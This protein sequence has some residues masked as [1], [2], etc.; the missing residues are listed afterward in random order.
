MAQGTTSV[1]LPAGVAAA[2]YLRLYPHLSKFHDDLVILAG[3]AWQGEWPLDFF[4][5]IGDL[6]KS[7]PWLH[8]QLHA[9]LDPAVVMAIREQ[10]HIPDGAMESLGAWKE[11]FPA[12]KVRRGPWQFEG[13]LLLSQLTWGPGVN[14]PAHRKLAA[15][16]AQISHGLTRIR[17]DGRPGQVPRAHP[18]KQ[19]M[20]SSRELLTIEEAGNFLKEFISDTWPSYPRFAQ[21]LR[22]AYL[23]LILGMPRMWDASASEF[24][25]A[26]DLLD[27]DKD[28][29]SPVSSVIGQRPFVDF[30]NLES[31]ELPR[32]TKTFTKVDL[33]E[34][35]LVMV[36]ELTPQKEAMTALAELWRGEKTWDFFESIHRLRYWVHWLTPALHQRFDL[37]AVQCIY[38]TLHTKQRTWAEPRGWRWR[39][40]KYL[41]LEIPDRPTALITPSDK[42]RRMGIFHLRALLLAG[43]IESDPETIAEPDKAL[44][45]VICDLESRFRRELDAEEIAA[46]FKQQHPVEFVL[47]RI[48]NPD[49][50]AGFIAAI[51]LLLPEISSF[52]PNLANLL[53]EAYLPVLK[54]AP[55]IWTPRPEP[56]TGEDTKRSTPRKKSKRHGKTRVRRMR[57]G[58]PG[59]EKPLPGE[60][61]EETQETLELFRR[62]EPRKKAVSLKKELLWVH[63]RV[64]GANP[65]LVRNHF[66]SICDAEAALFVQ[67]LDARI[68]ADLSAKEVTRA[69]TGI[70]VALVLLTGQGPRTWAE[71]KV[72]LSETRRTGNQPRLLLHK[73][74]FELPIV[75]PENSFEP[76]DV[77]ASL[78]EPTASTIA[79]HLPPKLGSRIKDLFAANMDPWSRDVEALRS[80]LEAYVADVAPDVG[81]GITLPRVR[82]F[83]RA[84]L[85]EVTGD[86]CATMILCGDTFGNSTAPLYYSNLG[87]ANLEQ[88]F[89]KAM[90][91]LFGDAV[92]VESQPPN[93]IRVGSALLVKEATARRLAR[94]PG[95]PMQAAGKRKR[96]NHSLV[97]DHNSLVNH[98]LCMLMGSMAHRPTAA[99]L[100]LTRF[101][102][103]TGLHAAIFRDKQSDPAHLFRY[104]PTSDLVSKQIDC[105]LDH[106]RRLAELTEIPLAA[107]SKAKS[108]LLG[109]SSLF[110]HLTSER[111][112]VDLE[113]ETWP[114]TLPKAWDALPLNWGRTW[115]S[116]RGRKAGIDPDHLSIVLGHLEA[117]GYPFSRES[118]LEPAQLS[119][120]IS[121][122]LGQ[123]ARSEGWILRKGL[124]T[125]HP[126]AFRLK[127]LGPLRDWKEERKNLVEKTK[128]YQVEQKQIRWS[129]LKSK[130][131]EGER[132]AHAAL[133]SV[134]ARP[135]AAFERFGELRARNKES[136]DVPAPGEQPIVLSTE[137]L[138]A[139]QD[140]I[141][142]ATRSNRVLTIAAHSALR[143]YLQNAK[144]LLGWDSPVPNPWL[145]PQTL[146]PTPFFPGLLRATAQ[147]RALRDHFRDIPVKP[148]GGFSA[149]EWACGTSVIALAAFGFEDSPDRI[150]EILQGRG[151]GTRCKTL[152]DMLLIDVGENRRPV[153]VRG[154]GAHAVSRL[155]K[156]FP[157][158]KVPDVARLSEVLAE[159]IPS[160]LTD[161]AQDL[162][163]RLCATVSVANLV[164]LSGLARVALS[165]EGGCV[166]M[167]AARQRQFLEEGHGPDGSAA[168]GNG[169]KGNV[170]VRISDRRCVQSVARQQYI[171]LRETLFIGEGPKKFEI[172]GETLSQANITA[173]RGPLR[174]ELTAFLTQEHLSPLVSCIGAFALDM[175][176]N[177]TRNRKVPAWRTVHGYVT[178]FGSELIQLAADMDFMH[179]DP[180][181]YI[182]LYQDVLDHKDSG[183]RQAVAAREIVD[184]HRYLQEHHG[185][186]MV[187]FSDLEGV[188]GRPDYQVDAEVVLPQ[189]FLRGL[190]NM[191]AQASIFRQAASGN[192][193]RTRLHRQAEVFALL[194]RGSGAR[195]NELAALRFKDILATL[196]ATVLLIRPSRYRRLKTSAARRIVDCSLKL[197]HRQ[198]RIVSEWIAAERSRLSKAWKATLPIF[199]KKDNPK[200][201]VAS[202]DLRDVTL[203]A[204]DESV[205]Y[206]SKIHRIRHLVASEDLLAIW[207]SESDWRAL[208]HS[209]VRGR[210]LVRGRRRT[211]VVL[212][213]HIRAQSLRFGHRHSSTTLANYFHMPWAV[214]SRA[215]DTLAPYVDRRSAAVALGVSAAGA[216]KILQRGKPSPT[217]P[218]RHRA[219]SLWLTHA[220][221]IVPPTPGRLSENKQ[222]QLPTLGSASVSARLV[223]RV[224]RDIQRGLS[225]MQTC[226]A[227]GLTADQLERLQ[228]CVAEVEKKTAFKITPRSP[229]KPSRSARSFS[230]A[231]ELEWILDVFDGEPA[232]DNDIKQA[233]A[234]SL[235]YMLWANKS[236]RDHIT[237]PRRDIDRLVAVLTKLGVSAQRIVRYPVP[238]EKGFERVELLRS[239]EPKKSLN[240]ALAWSLVVI[241]VATSVSD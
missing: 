49:T 132:I 234:V 104:V 63:Q 196:E 60:S 180:E 212:P 122:R 236:K 206:R 178:S 78:L 18:L 232:A 98:V 141:D 103:D 227:H 216:D 71:A 222:T 5:K 139:V 217:V 38:E 209:R 148:T 94:G 125:E 128:A 198:K 81:T 135:I 175:T 183:L 24:A 3:A 4:E 142:E 84:R 22:D 65:L 131:D 16:L 52:H 215:H 145:A 223:D 8:E 96:E 72:V 186:E 105:Y 82:N 55:I 9:R 89:R 153:G 171:R 177:G 136:K 192:A 6:T 10:R 164:E 80:S 109:E 83:A 220:A 228:Q 41:S 173:F 160:A 47:E 17:K 113:I 79:L 54:G 23:P 144:K 64:W 120:E 239:T 25:G 70:L 205:G 11:Q 88:S 93:K 230:D 37:E 73:G 210:R 101:D 29:V 179:L 112:P 114:T 203:G 67:A 233:R 240:H 126:D 201:R 181:E 15:I 68:A 48:A 159:Q 213:R 26:D 168:S 156:Q 194:L 31:G 143:R 218:A 130:R 182:D 57:V 224:L 138:E 165:R 150:F 214:A 193:E 172:T 208:R 97:S 66:E 238:E 59:R 51:E 187:D 35:M 12:A 87:V 28:P 149:F 121:A 152:E 115:L 56:S 61:L 199:S 195:H 155:A 7:L 40:Q 74:V 102:F 100:K 85:R 32:E 161:N 75:R 30:S 202:A 21:F 111:G 27:V 14:E 45:D 13:F 225:L 2:E 20:Y 191:S 33:V 107:S 226:L 1:T 229:D 53:Q 189:E 110:F 106:L 137:T 211:G 147:V 44:S 62:R 90:W 108:A 157:D 118:P 39:R 163:P 219:A 174:R 167:P 221:G 119:R 95:A 162:L 241:Y 133:E 237:W 127:E 146:E 204:L 140:K 86:M 184:F 43:R 123:L 154:L 231:R 77:A 42:D 170:D 185:F 91:P 50:P 166:A 134:L 188:V 129:N 151:K 169:R 34:E 116:S 235:S 158:D 36:K 190:A 46:G 99:L 124:R 207:L 58:I 69:R 176:T 76:D 19:R 117:T 200:E 92:P 197:S